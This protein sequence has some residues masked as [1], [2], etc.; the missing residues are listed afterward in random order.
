M[1]LNICV[2]ASS[3]DALDQ[4]YY[5]AATRLGELIAR[6]GHTLIYG[7]GKIGLMGAVA[8]GVHA[9]GG[10][11]IGVIPEKLLPQGYNGADEM[12]IT[13]TMRERKATMEARSD[14]FVVLPGAF[15]TLEEVLEIIT[16]KQ[17]AYHDKPIT[18]VN[19]AGYYDPLV[20]MFEH[21]YAEQFANPV[22]RV[23]YHV[24]DRPSEALAYIEQYEPTTLPQKW[25]GRRA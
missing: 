8:R 15:G 18:L 14:A 11:V 16:L 20:Q 4:Q 13:K 19:T 7:G 5:D 2:Y 10:H 12:I 22:Y 1:T 24:A 6:S 17:L 9:H 3:S 21:I 23:L 25:L